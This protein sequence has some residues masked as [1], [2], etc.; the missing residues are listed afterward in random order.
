MRNIEWTYANGKI[1][2]SNPSA[3]HVTLVAMTSNGKRLEHSLVI[4]P[5]QV[6][7]LDG[8]PGTGIGSQSSITYSA[9]T[10]FGAQDTYRVTL[11]GDQ[12]AKGEPT[13]DEE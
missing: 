13:A 10:D 12:P 5:G 3:Y 11:K 9:V 6:F 4:A 7:T 2:I 1:R 8:A